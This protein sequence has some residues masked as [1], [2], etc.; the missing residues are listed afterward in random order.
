MPLQIAMNRYHS[1]P[2]DIRLH[3]LQGDQHLAP[4]FSI[5]PA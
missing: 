5:E 2:D 4:L 1:N 3:L